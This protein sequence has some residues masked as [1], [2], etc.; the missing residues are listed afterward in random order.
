MVFSE[1]IKPEQII[2]IT[3]GIQTAKTSQN[4]PK[5]RPYKQFHE[6]RTAQK[7]NISITSEHLPLILK[8]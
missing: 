4:D 1:V 7:A 5:N 2:K 3:V 6:Q 8:K